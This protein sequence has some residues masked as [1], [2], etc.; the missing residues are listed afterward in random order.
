[1]KKIL[2]IG[3]GNVFSSM[4]HFLSLKNV[5]ESVIVV[6]YGDRNDLMTNPFLESG[7]LREYERV[8]L[9]P[10][11]ME[12]GV[13]F[14][15]HFSEVLDRNLFV[16]TED[17]HSDLTYKKVGADYVIIRK[18]EWKGHTWFPIREGIL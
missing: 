16:V 18:P 5:K 17:F 8:Y 6:Q 14:T 15:A 13:F 10:E 2:V 1:M 7:K 12:E 3:K 11:T 9:F 4:V